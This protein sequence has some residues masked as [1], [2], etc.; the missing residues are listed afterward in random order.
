[1]DSERSKAVV[2][3]DAVFVVVFNCKYG[4]VIFRVVRNFNRINLFVP[5]SFRPC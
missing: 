2:F 5:M 4:F 1:M 3:K